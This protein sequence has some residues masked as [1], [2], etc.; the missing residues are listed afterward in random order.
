[1][2]LVVFSAPF[3]HLGVGCGSKPKPKLKNSSL[4]G[5]KLEVFISG[6]MK[7]LKAC[8]MIETMALFCDWIWLDWIGAFGHFFLDVFQEFHCWRI[9]IVFFLFININWKNLHSCFCSRGGLKLTQKLTKVSVIILP[10]VAY[11]YKELIKGTALSWGLEMLSA[12]MWQESK[13]SNKN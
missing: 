11:W 4:I 3:L 1:M 13:D 7:F 8:L 12:R 6:S 5:S 9:L 2:D 10:Y